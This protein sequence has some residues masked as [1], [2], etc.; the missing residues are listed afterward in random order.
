M[1]EPDRKTFVGGTDIAAIMGL[2]ATYAG[3]QQTPFSVWQ[4]KLG[5]VDGEMDAGRR[6]FLDRRK[7]WEPVVRE[8]LQEEFGATITSFN[9]RYIDQA[10]PHF[11]A[12]ID[13][14]WL[15]P[16]SGETENGEIKT[17]SPR[18]FGER[19]GWGAPGTDEA[20]VHYAA[21]CMWGMMVARRRKCVLAAMVGLDEMLFYTINRDEETIT[22]MREAALVFWND[23]VLTKSPPPAQTWIDMQRLM[24]RKRERPV[25][26]CGEMRDKLSELQMVR[27]DIA[28]NERIAEELSF[29]LGEFVCQAWDVANPY[30]SPAAF[31]LDKKT[32]QLVPD[33]L[34]NGGLYFD[35]AKAGTWNRQTTERIDSERLRSELPE[36]ARAFTK[37]TQSRVL[38]ISKPKPVIGE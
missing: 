15:D 5:E 28:A 30:V 1:S 19:Y 14:E 37:S 2:G 29:E 33:A 36:V 20:P 4:K 11:A 10:V 8:M 21:Q 9:Q 17:V 7:R 6:L 16:E 26:L 34:E 25:Q 22:S 23:Y 24:L 31:R 35:G 3:V 32:K 18:A 13:F 27:A 12:E 38:R